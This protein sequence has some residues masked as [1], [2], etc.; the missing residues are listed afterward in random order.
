MP[1]WLI[2]ILVCAALL[3]IA[4]YISAKSKSKLVEKGLIINREKDFMEKAEIFTLKS[5]STDQLLEGLKDINAKTKVG[6]DGN[7]QRGYTF[8]GGS[9]SRWKARLRCT[10]MNESQS[11]FRFVFTEW[12]TENDRPKDDISMNILLTAVEKMFLQLDPHTQVRTEPVE[13]HTSRA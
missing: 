9:Y 6:I 3:V 1:S 5:I 12:K 10:E 4:A 11:I 7:M 13:I 8:D 2:A